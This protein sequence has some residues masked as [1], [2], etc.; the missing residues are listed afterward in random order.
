MPEDILE[1]MRVVFRGEALDLLLELDTAL[2]ALEGEPENSEPVNRI[3]RAIHT[4]KG[5][6]ATAGFAHLA[7]FAHRLEETFDLARGGHL[8]VT[9][10][11]IDCGLKACDVIRA[12]LLG[13]GE[14][15]EAEGERAVTESLTRLLSRD[16]GLLGVPTEGVPVRPAVVQTAYEIV[17]RPHGELFCSGTDPVTLLDDLRGLGPAHITARTDQVPVISS[18]DPESCYLWWEILLITDRGEAAIREVF[19]FVEDDC[20]VRIRMLEDQESAVAMLASIP[21]ESLDLFVQECEEH[22]AAIESHALALERDPTSRDSI[23]ALFRSVHSIK[24]NTGILLGQV[25]GTTLPPNHPL[26]LLRRVAHALESLLD[27][28]RSAPSALGRDAIQTALETRDAM[29]RLLESLARQSLAADLP[30]DLL[31]RLQLED[32]TASQPS[33]ERLAAFLNTASQCVEMIGGCLQ[34][35]A[36]ES[37]STESVLQAYVRGLKT[38]AAAASYRKCSGLDDPVAKQLRILN[39]AMRAGGA[40]DKEDRARLT[41]AFESACSAVDRAKSKVADSPRQAS[42]PAAETPVDTAAAV[43]PA[44]PSTIRIDQEKLDRLMRVVGELL[45]ARGAFPVLAQRL[46]GGADSGLLAKELKEAGAGISRIADEL[47]NSVMSIRMLPVKTVFQR[48]PRLVRDLARSLGKE[49]QFAM[50]GESIE[51]DKTILEQIG[52]PLVHLIRNAVDHGLEEPE[53]RRSRGK[54]PAGR[55]TLR[56]VSEAGAVVIQVA[57][58]GAG[59]DAEALKR[60]AVEKGFLSL[61]IAASMD[62]VAAFQLIFLPGLTTARKV[63]DVSGRGVGM[64][65]VRNNIRNLQGAIEIQS[66]RGRGTTFS[67]RLPTS[68]MISKGILLRA[69][70]EEYVLPL[71]SI[72]DMV[73][74]PSGEIHGYRGA[75]IVHIRGEVYPVFSLAELFGA[76]TG[77]P[78]EVPIAIVEAGNVRYGLIVEQFVSEVEVIV[79]PLSGGLAEC[80]E[81]QGAAIMGDGRVVLV[82]NPLECHRLELA[83]RM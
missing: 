36:S 8:A 12:I 22:L 56:A 55:V 53:E 77:E 64:D 74:I 79:K 51:L 82:L 70:A 73:K 11:L 40:V 67:V 75:S 63:T 54:D 21:A 81:F 15:A 17:F 61:D 19:V 80:K 30:A 41:E 60:K 83:G 29:R 38:L 31:L 24:G 26:S 2:L 72:R 66:T 44:P 47:Q 14:D 45:V 4:I 7:R 34:S 3:F 13:E 32:D 25:S 71:G 9:A 6:G 28:F 37:G 58:D 1:Q 59:L 50:E 62:E 10:E 76:P 23:D 16:G 39:T 43:R 18:L 68:L 52:D 65:V 69:G 49:V 48:F 27:P 35:I 33:D 20:E 42:R 5:S 46:A 78:S 57:D